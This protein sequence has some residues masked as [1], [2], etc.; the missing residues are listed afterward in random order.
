M[1]EFKDIHYIPAAPGFHV[2]EVSCDDSLETFIVPIIAWQIVPVRDKSPDEAH[3]VI[4]PI[5]IQEGVRLDDP[6][7]LQPNGEITNLCQAWDNMDAL[8]EY[9]RLEA[10]DKAMRTQP[11]PPPGSTPA[12]NP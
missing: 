1:F 6:Y 8:K 4:N 11:S 2:V 10:L 5:T 3:A 9:L 7:I 12:L